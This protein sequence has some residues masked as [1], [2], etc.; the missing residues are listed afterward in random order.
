MPTPIPCVHRGADALTVMMG[1]FGWSPVAT[2]WR[3]DGLAKCRVRDRPVRR[4][5]PALA[6][7]ASARDACSQAPSDTTGP[8]PRGP[9]ARPRGTRRASPRPPNRAVPA[10]RGA[11]LR[12]SRPAQRPRRATA[13]PGRGR[14]WRRGRG[15]QIQARPCRTARTCGRSS[16]RSRAGSQ[17]A[18]RGRRQAPAV[19]VRRIALA[20]TPSGFVSDHAP[21][22]HAGCVTTAAANWNVPDV[23][24]P[25]TGIH[26]T[27]PVF[28]R[29]FSRWSGPALLAFA[30]KVR[31][32]TTVRVSG[33]VQRLGLTIS[34]ENTHRPPLHVDWDRR[35]S[36]IICESISLSSQHSALS[37][38]WRHLSARSRHISRVGTAGSTR[39]TRPPVRGSLPPIWHRLGVVLGL[40]VD[41]SGLLGIL[42]RTA[43]VQSLICGFGSCRTKAG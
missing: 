23:P 14:P 11:R 2:W 7:S 38:T 19:A 9:A 15:G 16:P 6:P 4:G 26:G 3:I 24:G 28:C 43:T 30:G 37:V 1:L 5:G 40:R 31:A 21:S 17:A 42:S 10:T 34:A 22:S 25:L 33:S 35:P 8:S 36:R 18:M 29:Y 27:N 12:R 39:A 13:P 41:A 20:A 32:R